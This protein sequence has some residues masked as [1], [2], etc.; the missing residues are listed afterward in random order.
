MWDGKR[1][2]FNTDPHEVLDERTHGW[3][4]IWQC[5]SKE[6]RART[7]NAIKVAIE[8]AEAEG[9]KG[10][11]ITS[12]KRLAET[13]SSFKK[14]TSVGLDLWAIKEFCQCAPE[15]LDKLAELLMEWDHAITALAQ[16]LVNLMAM[17]PKKKGHRT[18]A[19]MASGHR[20][21]SMKLTNGNGTL[22]IHTR[23]IRQSLT[24]HASG[25][26]KKDSWGKKSST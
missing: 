26:P 7:N 21:A 1:K 18:V 24:L 14:N 5:D 10:A 11:L 9:A 4:S 6:A 20:V 15:D 22:T 13:A 16:W 19:A 3:E 25:R 12:G 2:E 8:R 17:I 23:T